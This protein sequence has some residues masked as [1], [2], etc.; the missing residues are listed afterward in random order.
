L[1]VLHGFDDVFQLGQSLFKTV[2]GSGFSHDEGLM[3]K[4]YL[5]VTQS[6]WSIFL[7]RLKNGANNIARWVDLVQNS[8][9]LAG[10]GLRKLALTTFFTG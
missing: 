3:G 5:S 2:R 7:M 1:P 9:A 10:P 6:S 4:R 8:A